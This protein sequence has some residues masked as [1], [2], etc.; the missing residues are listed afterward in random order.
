MWWLGWLLA[1]LVGAAVIGIVVYGLITKQ[2][3][4]E[5]LQSQGIRRTIVSA[6]DNCSNVVTLTDLDNNTKIEVRGDGI[7][8]DI[9][10]NDII[11]V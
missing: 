10:E 2:K 3:I 5:Q 6:I 8:F 7:A 4:R 9:Q 1:G 11:T